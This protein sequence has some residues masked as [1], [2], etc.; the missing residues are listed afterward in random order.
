MHHWS[1][2]LFPI[3]FD[4]TLNTFSPLRPWRQRLLCPIDS[5]ITVK[6]KTN[7]QQHSYKLSSILKTLH[8]DS[9]LA[10]IKYS[11]LLNIIFTGVYTQIAFLL[12]IYRP[13]AQWR[14]G[15]ASTKDCKP[16]SYWTP[17]SALSTQSW[18][19]RSD[20]PVNPGRSTPADHCSLR[21]WWS[22]AEANFTPL[23]IVTIS[24]TLTSIYTNSL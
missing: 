5:I 10:K 2:F 20:H 8:C 14:C 6:L 11:F 24:G 3:L 1:D 7:N 23:W 4:R 16:G 22:N 17:C 18:T 9:F 13:P 15:R 12:L 19:L 21:G